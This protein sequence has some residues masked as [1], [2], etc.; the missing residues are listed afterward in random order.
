LVKRV[1]RR[2]KT[3]KRRYVERTQ[4][5]QQQRQLQREVEE[6]IRQALREAFE[7]ALR[8]E[9]TA[10]LG[11]AK[12]ERRDP[13]DSTVVEARRNKCGTI[14]IGS[15]VMGSMSEVSC[16]WMPALL[17]WSGERRFGASLRVGV[18]R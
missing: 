1:T 18:L 9:V 12:S 10:L 17:N 5:Q 13:T 16:R 8:D 6:T 15:A 3:R 4:R 11:R 2:E 14:A 7:Q